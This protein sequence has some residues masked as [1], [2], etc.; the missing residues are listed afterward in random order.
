MCQDR[1]KVSSVG[2][3]LEG[4]GFQP[5][6]WQGTTLLPTFDAGSESLRLEK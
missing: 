6:S 5:Y 1:S 4:R 2:M 3:M